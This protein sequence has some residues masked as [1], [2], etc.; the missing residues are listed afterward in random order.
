MRHLLLLV[1]LILLP[2]LSFPQEVEH[3]MTRKYIPCSDVAY[4]SSLLIPEHYRKG[5]MDTVS[6]LMQYWETRCGIGEPLLRLKILFA[7]KGDTFSEEIYEDVAIISSLLYSKRSEIVITIGFDYLHG[8][9]Y[10]LD[11][12]FFQFVQSLA[13][14]L[15]Q[16]RA[17]S[18]IEQF[19]LDFYAGD[20]DHIFRRVLDTSL[21]ATILQEAYQREAATYLRMP[22]GHFSIYS[23]IWMPMGNA[24][25]LGNH[26]LIGFEGGLKQKRW[27]LDAL[28]EF[29]FLRSPNTYLVVKDDSTFT[30]DHFFGGQIGL[31]GGYELLRYQSNEINLLGGIAWDGF[32]A[33]SIGEVNDPDRITKTI[34]A[35]NLNLGIGY[36][37]YFRDKSYIGI[38]TRYNF[39]DYRNPGGT[40]LDG[41]TLTIRLKYGLSR[42]G[43][44]DRNLRMLDHPSLDKEAPAYLDFLDHGRIPFF[45]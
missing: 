14:A 34:N 38:D 18:P 35:L 27:M 19:F 4:N 12:S 37:K 1:A 16:E 44:R 32:D 40:D 17:Y 45:R 13:R 22:E 24:S 11:Y 26:P 15:R 23:G 30:T 28:V 21:S 36:R 33:L 2:M 5:N 10:S 29:K 7:I 9:H 41:H 42:N 43:Y 25:I 20:V 39:V 6:A 3:L 31:S 8:T